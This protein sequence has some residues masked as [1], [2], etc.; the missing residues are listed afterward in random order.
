M[1]LVFLLILGFWIL[2]DWLIDWLLFIYKCNLLLFFWLL[3]VLNYCY[4]D[5][6]NMEVFVC[7]WDY[8]FGNEKGVKVWVVFIKLLKIDV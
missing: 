7:C 4:C 3:K 2:I 8:V 1:I 5:M 6:E